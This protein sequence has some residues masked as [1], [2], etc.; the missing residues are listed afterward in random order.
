MAT[1]AG[2]SKIESYLGAKAESLLGF[3]SPRTL[4]GGMSAR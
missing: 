4:E 1:S 2:F 3:K